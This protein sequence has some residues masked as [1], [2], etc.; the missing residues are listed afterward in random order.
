MSPAG[1]RRRYSPFSFVRTPSCAP[2]MP[3]VASV[4]GVAV[5][6]CVT[7]PVISRACA[8]AAASGAKPRMRENDT[9]NRRRTETPRRKRGWWGYWGV[10]IRRVFGRSPRHDGDSAYSRMAIQPVGGPLRHTIGP[11]YPVAQLLV[12]R[13]VRAFV[14][15][16]LY[17]I[18]L[19]SLVALL[20]SRVVV[21]GPRDCSPTR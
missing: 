14:Q 19:A 8:A 6:T 4:I 11:M 10:N 20:S 2:R 7:L 16:T 12:K 13:D 5:P 1:T 9:A 18:F 3:M 21:I 17:P 15:C